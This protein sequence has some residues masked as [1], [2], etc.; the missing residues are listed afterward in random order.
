M[1]I[2]E[3]TQA[4]E[5]WSK[6][7]QIANNLYNEGKHNDA[8]RHY[9]Q[10]LYLSEIM[11]RNE[12]DAAKFEI[13]IASPFFVSCL[14][15][16]NNF[17]ALNDFK[18]AG[19]YFFYNVWHLKALATKSKHNYHLHFQSSKN[20]EK[21]VLLLIDFYK[22]TGQKL[23]VDFWKDETYDKISDTRKWL[24]NRQTFLN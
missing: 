19:D 5:N 10:V 13:E 22:Q 8:T 6:L 16:A 18:N 3:F 14:N 4:T 11:F 24:V 23:T 20:W 17:W 21:A 7:T 15:L 1:S 2:V 12:N 9:Q